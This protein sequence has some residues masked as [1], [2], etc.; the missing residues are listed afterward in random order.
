VTRVGDGVRVDLTKDQV[1]DLPP[2]DVD[3]PD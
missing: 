2:I 1:R 3:E